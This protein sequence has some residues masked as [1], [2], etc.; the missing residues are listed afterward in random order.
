MIR[1]IDAI[2][3]EIYYVRDQLDRKKYGEFEENYVDIPALLREADEAHALQLY[4]KE[5]ELLESALRRAPDS[6]RY[7]VISELV[8]AHR[9]L[10][11]F[12]QARLYSARLVE[13]LPDEPITLSNHAIMQ[14]NA[15]QLDD[16]L[17]T[18]S[19]AA[20]LASGDTLLNIQLMTAGYL[21]HA[22]MRSEGEAVF[23]EIRP[24]VESS[25]GL[26]TNLAWYLAV[27]GPEDEFYAALERALQQS[28]G[29]TR[30]W[31]RIEVDLQ[32]Y[33]GQPRFQELE[34]RYQ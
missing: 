8:R 13:L 32:K 6:L 28:P 30:D 29:R 31:M 21:I 24:Q 4:Q 20:S 33:R 34:S 23:R 22:Q 26:A 27:A 19:R 18:L 9:A 1:E 25:R 17:R 5:V 10:R 16:A 15:G 7:A 14:K 3:R 2:R 11:Q 12:D